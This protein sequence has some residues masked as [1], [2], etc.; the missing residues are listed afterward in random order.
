MPF[1]VDI[2]GDV[3][4]LSPFYPLDIR[5]AVRR[6]WR[7]QIIVTDEDVHDG[8]PLVIQQHR[9]LFEEHLLLTHGPSQDSALMFEIKTKAAGFP[10]GT[11]VFPIQWNG[12]HIGS[13][14]IEAAQPVRTTIAG[15]GPAKPLNGSNGKT[16]SAPSYDYKTNL[17]IFGVRSLYALV[18]VLLFLA[19]LCGG[20]GMYLSGKLVNALVE[21]MHL[22]LSPMH[23]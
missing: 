22:V 15:Y 13:L 7:C 16:M 20:G 9:D 6:H 19:L 8:S 21:E 5:T 2:N 3:R 1:L 11:F 4:E 17:L 12:D 23:P 18:G 10:E 14:R